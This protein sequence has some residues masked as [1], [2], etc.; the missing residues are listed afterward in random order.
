ML[1][2]QTL[3]CA[4]PTSGYKGYALNG[5]YARNNGTAAVVVIGRH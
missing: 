5:L 3:N 4:P 2:L 1:C